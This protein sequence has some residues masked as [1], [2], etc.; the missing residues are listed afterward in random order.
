M[1]R[2]DVLATV[3]VGATTA[4]AG[5]GVLGGESCGPGED[6]IGD[7]SDRLASGEAPE[8][9]SLTGAA[10]Q[11]VDP[12]RLDVTGQ[13]LV[14]DDGTGKAIAYPP[15]AMEF[16]PETIERGTCL[17]L[18]SSLNVSRSKTLELPVLMV[19][20][21]DE[22]E[23]DGST[24]VPEET[25][26]TAPDATFEYEWMT[27]K[28][29]EGQAVTLHHRDGDAVPA[30]QLV[31]EYQGDHGDGPRYW[32]EVADDVGADDDVQPGDQIYVGSERGGLVWEHSDSWRRPLVL[33]PP[34]RWSITF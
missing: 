30:D 15:R 14:L 8:S 32:H 22:V 5:C 28:K 4:T 33:W 27:A 21:T 3:G 1:R 34:G 24:S 17:T 10:A 20:G 13:L 25:M 26:P 2:R 6:E 9:V 23:T 16:N 31:V 19:G 18:E 7:V 29:Y 11:Y 12:P